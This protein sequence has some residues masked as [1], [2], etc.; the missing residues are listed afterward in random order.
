MFF[1]YADLGQK[2]DFLDLPGNVKLASVGFN[3]QYNIARNFNLQLEVGSQLRRTPDT[4]KRDA[5][6]Q[7]VTSLAF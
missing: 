1:D 6:V 5:M 7:V 4:K 3:A 2:T